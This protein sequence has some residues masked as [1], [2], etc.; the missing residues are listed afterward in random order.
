[1][2]GR[3]D[4]LDRVT[5][6]IGEFEVNTDYHNGEHLNGVY[7]AHKREGK[8]VRNFPAGTGEDDNYGYMTPEQAIALGTALVAAGHATAF[9]K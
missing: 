6:K 9:H 2:K 3:F 8:K 1:M 4:M 5:F 7:L